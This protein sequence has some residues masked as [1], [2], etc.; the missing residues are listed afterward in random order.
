[1]QLASPAKG[2]PVTIVLSSLLL[3]EK[4]RQLGSFLGEG[5]APAPAKAWMSPQPWP[6]PHT[7]STKSSTGPNL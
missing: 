2:S 3:R 4:W 1:M 7:G 6:L 5:G